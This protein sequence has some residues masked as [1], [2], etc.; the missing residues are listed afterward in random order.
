VLAPKTAVRYSE[1]DAVGAFSAWTDAQSLPA[2]RAFHGAAL[3]TP[4]NAL[5]DTLQAGHL[6]VV[7]GI[8]DTAAPTTSVYHS[9]VELDRSNPVWTTETALPA[10]LHS[11]GVAVF[12][13][14][15][16]VVGGATTGNAP[17]A[18]VYR[19]RINEDG[20]L[21]SWESQPSL[22]APRAYPAVAQAAGVLYALGGETA[23][24]APGDGTLTGTRSGDVHY[25]PLNLRTGELSD[26]SWTANPSSMIKDR[27]KH[28]AVAAGGW[29]LVSGGLY[30]GSGSSST[31]HS[32]ADIDLDGTLGSFGG[33]T[34]SQT[35]V[36]AG[37]VPFF[38]HGALGYVDASG[39]AHV[40][41]LGGADVNAPSSAL[42]GV[43]IY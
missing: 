39:E 10:P 32:F 16:Y 43:W 3:A 24:N 9:T 18:E 26:P 33:A 42:A 21:G 29:V 34:G 35:I 15:L 38:N 1:I 25:N 19:A 8:D 31:E 6:Y 14:W 12:R 17:V 5:V 37:G 11:M 4:F 36:A 22:P 7:G 27:A 13:S 2:A 40:V 30:N 28:T 23:A 20:S 41:I